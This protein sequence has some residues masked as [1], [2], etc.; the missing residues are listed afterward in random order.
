MCILLLLLGRVVNVLVPLAYKQLIG[1]LGEGMRDRNAS[2]EMYIHEQLYINLFN[3]I[4]SRKNVLS[5][6]NCSA[7]HHLRAISLRQRIH[8]AR[9]RAFRAC[10]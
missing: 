2:N 3:K 7:P 10:V 1:G 4:I 8:L 6:K 5:S 9:T